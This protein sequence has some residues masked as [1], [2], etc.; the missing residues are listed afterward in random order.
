M[1]P[2]TAQRHKRCVV[3]KHLSQG[4]KNS[5]LAADAEVS[6]FVGVTRMSH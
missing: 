3:P 5:P 1:L 6:E 4:I 2:E